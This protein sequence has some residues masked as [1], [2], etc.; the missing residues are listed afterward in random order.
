MEEENVIN[1]AT[2]IKLYV[3]LA[4]YRDDVVGKRKLRLRTS[5]CSSS[6]VR[7][8][9]HWESY[10]RSRTICFSSHRLSLS[11]SRLKWV[12][13]SFDVPSLQ[14]P[15]THNVTEIDRNSLFMIIRWVSFEKKIDHIICDRIRGAMRIRESIYFFL[16][17]FLYIF[18]S[19]TQLAATD[20]ELA[21]N[22]VS[23][24][25]NER[26]VQQVLMALL[27]SRRAFVPRKSAFCRGNFPL[28]R[29]NKTVHHVHDRLMNHSEYALGLCMCRCI[30]W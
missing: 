28:W 17:V 23:Y 1:F 2:A 9:H 26:I 8:K 20:F 5:E 4:T 27:F 22:I 15:S 12:T 3:F 21:H 25:E 6:S 11:S 14:K 13:R 16:S 29:L 19:P 7:R 18:S 10:D 30:E 24:D